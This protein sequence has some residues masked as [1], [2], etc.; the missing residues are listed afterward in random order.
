MREARLSLALRWRD[1][2]VLGHVN[3]SVY[4]ELLEEGRS[5]LFESVSSG[6][7]FVLARVEL[8]YLAELRLDQGQVELLTRVREIGRSSLVM[9]HEFTRSDGV[10]AA[11]GLSVVV[12]WDTE[13]RRSRP[14]SADERA[15]LLGD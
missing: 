12:A 14:L 7:P 4:H 5:A 9:E 8:D 6:F 3:Q 1:I 11:R 2:D 13:A 10:V 15:L